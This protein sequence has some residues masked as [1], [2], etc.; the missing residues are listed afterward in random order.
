VN[1]WSLTYAVN[2]LICHVGLGVLHRITHEVRRQV[3]ML[4]TGSRGAY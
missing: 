4:V 1:K 2:A 3:F